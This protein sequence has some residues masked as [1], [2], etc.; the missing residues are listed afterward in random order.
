MPK[1]VRYKTEAE[2]LKARRAG[3]RKTYLKYRDR[4]RR[5]RR[6]WAA[7]NKDIIKERSKR[8]YEKNREKLLEKTKK[9]Q[10][11]TGYK[12]KYYK[13]NIKKIKAYTIEYN[14]RPEVKKR[15]AEYFQKNKKRLRKSR[16][17]RA[18]KRYKNDLIFFLVE[19][20]RSRIRRSVGRANAK[21]TK[22]VYDLV[23]C[24]IP[25]LKKHL[26]NKFK[27][28]MS[29][30]NRSKWHI[31]HITPVSYFVKNYDFNDEK[32]QKK[33]FHFSNLQPLWKLENEMK[34]DKVDKNLK[35]K[36]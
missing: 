4:I 20:L 14:S 11:R 34:H 6:E 31:D 21:K 32:V 28:G 24:S 19:K 16:S 26:E 29:W 23:G 17:E 8:Y 10:I 13:K 7:A 1:G 15:R 5:E 9:Y 25:D 33:C 18:K 30:K 12:K 35:I 36:I 27:K 3:Q 22:G 2:R